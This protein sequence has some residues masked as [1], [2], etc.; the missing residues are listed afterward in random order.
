MAIYIPYK[1]TINFMVFNWN[2]TQNL[3]LLRYLVKLE[4]RNDAMADPD[5]ADLYEQYEATI[6]R[7]KEVHKE[8]EAIKN[9]G[10]GKKY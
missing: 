9:S 2:F 8:N 5:V 6:E 1:L 10:Y 4:I 7:F 3:F